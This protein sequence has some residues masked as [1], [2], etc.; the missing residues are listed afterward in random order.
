M[1]SFLPNS[2]K[3]VPPEVR[4]WNWGAF[5]LTWIWGIFNNVWIAFLSLI[6]V[7]HLVMCF[8]L[9]AKGNEWAWQSK[10]WDSVEHF[11]SVQRKWAIAAVI[12]LSLV[13]A[14]FVLVPFGLIGWD[15]EANFPMFQREISE[16]ARPYRKFCHAAVNNVERNPEAGG[17]LGYPV[18]V[19]GQGAVAYHKARNVTE[20][21]IPLSG[22]KQSGM[23]YV[24]VVHGKNG[25]E[26]AA[27]A[28]LEVDGRRYP[29]SISKA[30]AELAKERS[31]LQLHH[32]VASK[33][34][35]GGRDP[36]SEA[37]AEQFYRQCIARLVQNPQVQAVLG[38]NISA[39]VENATIDQHGSTGMAEFRVI[40]KGSANRGLA[41]I[42]GQRSMGRWSSDGAVVQVQ[43]R[44]QFRVPL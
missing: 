19:S 33:N 1:N 29:F 30:D 13:F 18:R 16:F 4:G 10:Q 7:V 14:A 2:D 34:N 31:D 42:M 22:A 15:V 24:L 23:L 27:K 44:G 37:E 21:S 26:H 25:S 20:V 11:H 8:I 36:E 12:I 41:D 28:E 3:S 32:V 17:M 5:F 6:P 40:L 38:G 43:G 39:S 9:G 35:W